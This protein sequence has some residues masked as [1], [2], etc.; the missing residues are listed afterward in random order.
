M[1]SS[2]DALFSLH[3]SSVDNVAK[4]AGSDGSSSTAV[5]GVCFVQNAPQNVVVSC[6][7]SEDTDSDSDDDNF[8]PLQFK[9]SNLLLGHG[10]QK[11]RESSSYQEA[12][13]LSAASHTSLAGVVLA[14]CHHDGTCKL[15]DLATRRCIVN[16]AAGGGRSGP[17]LAVRRLD[18]MQQFVYQS[19]DV[20]GTVSLHDIHRPL[21]PILQIHTYSTSFCQMAPCHITENSQYDAADEG[22][23]IA[24]ERNLIALPTHEQ[25]VAIIRDLRCDPTSNP[26]YRIDIGN[27]CEDSM[28]YSS[29][30]NY[31]MLTSLG[32]CQQ[33]K[34][35]QLVL[36][37]GMEDGSA[38]F[39][40]LRSTGSPWLLDH[41]A[42]ENNCS[43][44]GTLSRFMCHTK[45]GNDPVLSLDLSNS[46][47]KGTGTPS[48]VAVAGC[49]GDADELSEFPEAD[50][51][52]ISTIK[53]K[54]AD[55]ELT[56]VDGGMDSSLSNTTSSMRASVRSKTSTCSI[57]SGGKV[58]VSVCRFR[59]DGRI[60]AVGG[61]D[62]RLRLFDRASSKPLAILHGHEDTVTSVDWA[63]N[64]SSTGLLAT[65][66]GDGRICIYRVFPNTSLK[67]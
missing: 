52:T 58:G 61:W 1:L 21:D 64:A 50:Q 44:N 33:E 59:P 25:S 55:E 22:A 36:G 26:T 35:Q 37:C 32:L 62:R 20:L 56:N 17:G 29:R 19:R 42:E 2:T 47:S 41:S 63:G 6:D 23:T 5:T 34:A 4:N 9:S 67:R 11:H 10:D 40:D 53:I 30:R 24:G 46:L 14:S 39:Y 57:E 18:Q 13:H 66:A 65:G 28:L 43:S 51:G 8:E 38:L 31:G 15:W 27:D 12:T 3:T 54:L 48:L 60:F 16:D 7:D 49:A 45:L